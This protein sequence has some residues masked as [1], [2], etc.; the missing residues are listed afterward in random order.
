MSKDVVNKRAYP[1][2]MWHGDLRGVVNVGQMPSSATSSTTMPMD[3]LPGFS[4]SA[5]G[6]CGGRQRTTSEPPLP[7]GPPS[8]SIS[9][10]VSFAARS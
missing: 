9:A 10:G 4:R 1:L 2:S 6:T 5:H 8:C 7:A 3:R